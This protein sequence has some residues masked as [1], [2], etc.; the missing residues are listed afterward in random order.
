MRLV[1]GGNVKAIMAEEA[2][3][4]LTETA[5]SAA[6]SRKWRESLAWVLAEAPVT[7]RQQADIFLYTTAAFARTA[8]YGRAVVRIARRALVEGQPGLPACLFFPAF[9][10]LPSRVLTRLA[11]AV[12]ASNRSQLW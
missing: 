6:R 5:G 3:V 11:R 8:G 7:K 9:H 1:A 12:P 4:D 10:L 2:L